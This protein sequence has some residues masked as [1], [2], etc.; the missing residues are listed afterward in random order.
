MGPPA[1]FA[2]SGAGSVASPD[3]PEGPSRVPG[4]LLETATE[5]QKDSHRRKVLSRVGVYVNLDKEAAC[6]AVGALCDWLGDRGIDT[7]LLKEHTRVLGKRGGVTRDS[8]YR[9]PQLIIS[10]GGDGTFLHVARQIPRCRP[11]LLG[12][13]FGR[14]GFLTAVEATELLPFLERTLRSELPVEHRLRLA[15]AVSPWDSPPPALN[16][17]VIQSA[18]GVRVLGFRVRVGERVIGV[19]RAD[20]IIVASPTGSTAYT[21]SV[22][23]PVVHPG[24][25][26]MLIAL[27]SPHTL[28]ARPLVVGANETITVDVL[29]DS[30][31][32]VTID[33]QESRQVPGNESVRIH[34]ASGDVAVVVD[35][36]RPFIDRMREKL[37]WGGKPIL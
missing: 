19:F 34:R 24:V 8:F 31:I 17:V 16:D 15:T 27:I 12:V 25:E 9:K 1:G 29:S 28:S 5:N 23:G 18:E 37:A 22:G 36:Q 20:G 33:G 11:A 35:P 3:R 10:L 7:M 26:A 32:R 21:L 14:L 30:P 13:N 4:E 6:G 2:R